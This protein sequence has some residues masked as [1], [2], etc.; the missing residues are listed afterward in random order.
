MCTPSSSWQKYINIR[1]IISST[2]RWVCCLLINLW[3]CRMASWR[4]VI[5]RHS[6]YC[7]LSNAESN[8]DLLLQL[9][10]K[11]KCWYEV[12]SSLCWYCTWATAFCVLY[13]LLLICIVLNFIHCWYPRDILACCLV[14]DVPV[15]IYYYILW[16]CYFS[17]IS[18]YFLLSR[19]HLACW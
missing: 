17:Q 7:V 6:E 13:L 11:V 4:A 15:W 3:C 9:T 16:N 19:L 12:E 2:L 5:L 10:A 18:S 14:C 8:N 1:I